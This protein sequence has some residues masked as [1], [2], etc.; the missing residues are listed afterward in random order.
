MFQEKWEEKNICVE[1]MVLFCRVCYSEAF[2]YML[3]KA[4]HWS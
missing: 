2:I 1:A 3:F 4:V